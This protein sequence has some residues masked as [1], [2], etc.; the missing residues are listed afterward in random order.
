MS[1]AEFRRIV[2]DALASGVDEMALANALAVSRSTVQ[3]WTNGVAVPHPAMRVPVFAAIERLRQGKRQQCHGEG[4]A[5]V[6]DERD[7]RTYVGEPCS[8]CNAPDVHVTTDAEKREAIERWARSTGRLYDVVAEAGRPS[9]PMHE[10]RRLGWHIRVDEFLSQPLHIWHRHGMADNDVSA[11][12]FP[13]W[14]T[15]LLAALCIEAGHT[16]DVGRCPGCEGDGVQHYGTVDPDA[17]WPRQDWLTRGGPQWCAH[18]SCPSCPPRKMNSKPAR[19]RAVHAGTGR[20]IREVARLVLDAAPA[21]AE[22]SRYGSHV[23]ALHYDADGFAPMLA[24]TDALEVY[25]ARL[26]DAGN[27][28]GEWLLCWLLG[29][30]DSWQN[31]AVAAFHGLYKLHT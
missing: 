30:T 7:N 26:M 10:R 23:L 14:D 11:F 13:D 21:V 6:T 18:R 2:A 19:E 4:L 5:F 31:A 15:A 1:D 8:N 28:L 27:P 3:R 12:W 29:N 20:D 22:W 17:E 25:S 16:L 9:R 24:A